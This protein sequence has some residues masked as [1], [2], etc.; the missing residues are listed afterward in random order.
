M[1]K[2]LPNH[3][4]IDSVQCHGRAGFT[5]P[6]FSINKNKIRSC[7]FAVTAGPS[8]YSKNK[9]SGYGNA[10]NIRFCRPRE[11]NKFFISKNRLIAVFGLVIDKT[12]F[13]GKLKC[14]EY[15]ARGPRD[16]LAGR[17]GIGVP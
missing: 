13:C 7:L 8:G 1:R 14:F 6:L 11:N 9:N 4:R 10:A 16:P 12:I 15:N 17:Q 5:R 3:T 2:S